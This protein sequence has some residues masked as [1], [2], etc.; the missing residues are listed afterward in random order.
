MLFSAEYYELIQL[1]YFSY[2]QAYQDV[3]MASGIGEGNGPYVSFHDGFFP[4]SEWAGFL[5]NADR[6][7]L[8]DHPYICFGTQSAAPMSSYAQ[9][10]CNTWASEF[11]TSM[12]AFGLSGAGEFSNAVTDCGLWVNGVGLGTRYEGNYTGTWPVIGSCTPWNDWQDWNTTMKTDIMNFAMAS[13]DALQVRVFT[14][15]SSCPTMNHT[16]QNWF[17]WTWKIGASSVSG[18]VEAP[19]WSYSLGLQNGWM[20]LDPRTA[21]G[22]CADQGIWSP[23]LQPWQTGGAGAGQ[24][25]ASVI[26]E[27]AWPPATISNAGA[28]TLLPSYTPTGTV[29]TLP[30]PTFTVTSGKSVSTANAGKGWQ[31]ASDT[32]GEMVAIAT[33]SYLNP[34]IGPGVAPPSPLCQ[35]GNAARAVARST[36]TPPP[37]VPRY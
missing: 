19:Q 22:I 14:L 12:G 29:A 3:R 21:S 13:M 1:I 35:S 27:Y 34:W 36:I 5:P 17:F 28:V 2:L 9:T 11:N 33:C 31:N 30:P 16:T 25:A 4:L 18:V 32:A 24:V 7:A 15:C 6:I 20:P 26:Q 10:P 37:R 8:D 23:P